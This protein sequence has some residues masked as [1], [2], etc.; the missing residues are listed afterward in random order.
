MRGWVGNAPRLSNQARQHNAAAGQ[1]GENISQPGQ[2]SYSQG[3]AAAAQSVD[4]GVAAAGTLAERPPSQ[5]WQLSRRPCERLC[6]ASRHG[7]PGNAGSD[8]YKS[9]PKSTMAAHPTP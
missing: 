8:A 2:P 4:R 3:S 7:I 9:G 6:G 5:P 1:P